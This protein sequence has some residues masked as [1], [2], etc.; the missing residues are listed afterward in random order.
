V[1]IFMR[2]TP[3]LITK[4]FWRIR[5]SNGW[6]FRPDILTELVVNVF[7]IEPN[8]RLLWE[9]IA[10]QIVKKTGRKEQLPVNNRLPNF[11]KESNGL[12]MSSRNEIVFQVKKKKKPI[13]ISK[14]INKVKNFL[15]MK[16]AVR[17]LNLFQN[18]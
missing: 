13:T 14:T 10:L 15:S 17:F 2:E 8:Q 16:S 7:E 9:K 18:I 12:A 5:T 3:N 1:D 6:K 11:Q 4:Q